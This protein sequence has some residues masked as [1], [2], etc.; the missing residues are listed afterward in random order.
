MNSQAMYSF[1]HSSFKKLISESTL[2]LFLFL[3]AIKVKML[4]FCHIIFFEMSSFDIISIMVFFDLLISL[5]YKK[6][7]MSSF[8]FFPLHSTLESLKNFQ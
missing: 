7:Y 3:N 2:D 4:S 1:I 6:L 5:E 8:S